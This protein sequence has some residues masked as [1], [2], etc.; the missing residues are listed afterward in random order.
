MHK[1]ARMH[2]IRTL[3]TNSPALPH[4]ITHMSPDKA[5]AS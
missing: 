3:H 2:M 1:R 5:T 4:M